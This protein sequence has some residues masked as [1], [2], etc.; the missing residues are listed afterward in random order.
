MN[1]IS[2]P[3]SK[4]KK[5]DIKMNENNRNFIIAVCFFC[6]AGMCQMFSMVK[7][8]F[9]SAFAGEIFVSFIAFLTF[10]CIVYRV[11]RT[12][13][14]VYT[15][16]FSSIL[17]FANWSQLMLHYTCNSD[18]TE[19]ILNKVTDFTLY[20]IAAM[21]A[22][23]VMFVVINRI[24]RFRKLCLILFSIVVAG[25]SMFTILFSADDSNTSTTRSG[26]QPAI[27]MMFLMLYAF[28]C[29]M[30]GNHRF[31]TRIIYLVLFWGMMGLL[32]LKHETGVPAMTYA[33]C[34]VTYIFF[35]DSKKERWFTLA[36]T[37]ILAILLLIVMIVRTDVR[38]DTIKKISERFSE[39]EHW[40]MAEENLRT[41]SLFGSESYDVFLNE[42]SSDYALN[43]NVH[44]WGYIWLALMI[45][46]FFFMSINVYKNILNNSNDNI[47]SN[48]RKLTYIAIFINV[49]YNISDNICGT[50]VIGV[51]MIG[52]GISRSMALLTGLLIGSVITDT[53]KIES[54][55]LA[56]LE[57]TGIITTTTT[58]AEKT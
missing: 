46:S 36:N 9:F 52:C 43:V 39:N 38:T 16:S 5:E 58:S 21:I 57:K 44:Y 33:A 56:L 45:L 47:I 51:Q 26:F 19:N 32:V 17:L 29:A 8:S 6:V 7:S 13:S 2:N 53:N 40:L 48:L 50:P 22:V 20:V 12:Q 27:I 18:E 4:I 35:T 37:V 55:A 23:A 30:A 11:F 41:S 28:S 25:I 49:I 15:A 34:I 1:T 3:M 10:I 24:K 54:S 42:A 14:A 31:I